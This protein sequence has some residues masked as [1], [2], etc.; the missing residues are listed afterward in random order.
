[1]VEVVTMED[2]PEES[3]ANQAVREKLQKGN[4]YSVFA[5]A[6]GDWICR[7]WICLFNKPEIIW[8]HPSRF[9]LLRRAGEQP[10]YA[11]MLEEKEREIAGLKQQIDNIR[12]EKEVLQSTLKHWRWLGI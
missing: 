1:M 10:D 4:N 3:W 12:F 11:K 8:H 6:F 2:L 9:R 7:D 5:A